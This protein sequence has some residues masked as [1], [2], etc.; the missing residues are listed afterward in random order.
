MIMR[1]LLKYLIGIAVILPGAIAVSAMSMNKA[2]MDFSTFA[3]APAKEL[4]RW[5]SERLKGGVEGQYVGRGS[6]SPIYPAAP[7]KELLEHPVYP[8]YARLI[9]GSQSVRLP[10]SPSQMYPELPHD[11]NDLPRS[12]SYTETR[13]FSLLPWQLQLHPRIISGRELY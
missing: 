11:R 13:R 3:Q 12:L 8:T 9:K 1:V 2:F 6:L 7:G 4:P 5:T 10:K